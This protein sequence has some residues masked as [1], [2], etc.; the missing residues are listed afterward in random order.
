MLRETIGIVKRL[1]NVIILIKKI[2]KLSKGNRKKLTLRKGDLYLELIEGLSIN[3]RFD[4]YNLDNI[5]FFTNMPSYFKNPC[6]IYCYLSD[7]NYRL[8]HQHLI[9]N[10]KKNFKLGDNINSLLKNIPLDQRINFRSNDI[11]YILVIEVT[12]P[13]YSILGVSSYIGIRKK[14]LMDIFCYRGDL[15]SFG[16]GIELMLEAKGINFEVGKNLIDQFYIDFLKFKK[17]NHKGLI[18]LY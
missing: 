5:V 6:N 10:Y 9:V 16:G 1:K 13:R 7:H 12:P 18:S 14:N 15:S 2:D 11:N 4:S 17:C 3:I 8:Y